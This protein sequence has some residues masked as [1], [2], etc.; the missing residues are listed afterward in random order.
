MDDAL[1]QL[2]RLFSLLLG[3]GIAAIL[4]GLAFAW[5]IKWGAQHTKG[6]IKIGVLVPLL[7]LLVILDQTSFVI[8]S[9][10]LFRHMSLSYASLIAVLVVIGGYYAISTF[11]FPDDPAE[12]PSF[13][14]YYLNVSRLVVSGMIAIN[15]ATLAYEVLLTRA[16]VQLPANGGAGGSGMGFGD[17]ISLIAEL[18]FFP[19]LGAL[20]FV[21]S[22]KGSFVLLVACNLLMFFDA[23]YPL[24]TGK[25]RASELKSD[26]DD[27]SRLFGLLIGLAITVLIGG[28]ARCWRLSRPA[29]RRREHIRI[30][31]LVPLLGI[32]LVLNQASFFIKAFEINRHVPFSYSSLLAVL[33]LIGGYYVIST[34]VFPQDSR[35]W[36][37]FD[38]Y[39]P[40]VKRPVIGG[41]V[42]INAIIGTYMVALISRGAALAQINSR[43]PWSGHLEAGLQLAFLAAITGLFFVQGKRANLWMLGVAIALLCADAARSIA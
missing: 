17:P 43:H 22:R 40:T 21:R 23:L 11:V 12:W 31:W 39:Y 14:D 27:I 8:A 26:F 36:P 35:E 30:G 24:L 25:V 16:G 7:G 10:E 41:M 19:L 4:S 6:K 38:S 13:D 3:L 33:A 32:L 42:I 5:R 1:L 37:D 34:F 15:V 18:S 2:T 20:L 29:A 28:L 9:A